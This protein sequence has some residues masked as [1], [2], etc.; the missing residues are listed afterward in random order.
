MSFDILGIG[1]ALPT[2]TMSQD[3]ASAMSADLICRDERESRLLKTMLRRSRVVNRHTCVPHGI[4]Y[5]WVGEDAAPSASPG[6]TTQERM[7]LYA[8]HAGPLALEASAKA[9]AESAVAT[10]DISHLITVSCT[11]F[12]APG[13]DVQLIDQ[14]GLLQTTQRMHI[15]YMGCHGAI[16]GLRVASALA[17]SEPTARTLL[18]A[19]ELCSLHYRFQWDEER[20]LGNALFAD[21]AAALVGG[22]VASGA[23]AICRLKATGSCLVPDSRDT[24]TWRIGNH[25]FEMTLSN[26]VPDL[27]RKHLKPWLAQWLASHRVPMSAVGSWAVHPGGPRILDAVDEALELDHE[28]LAASRHV[29]E[30]FGN[31]SSPT[32]LF[33]LQRLLATTASRP[34]VALGFG[35]GLM[36]EAAL[37]E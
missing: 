9:L 37:I 24:I 6:P 30:Q 10:D 8:A 7:E 31:M 12:E 2:H 27:I 1:T 22:Q 35:P 28:A 29:L 14:L 34:C 32:V 5:E 3:E 33:I 18:C 19:T 25:G 11:G 23:Q 21:G 13:V 20:I 4:A 15:G 17:T 36:I 16:N 26:R